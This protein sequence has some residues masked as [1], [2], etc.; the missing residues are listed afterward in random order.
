MEKQEK[1]NNCL[2]CNRPL[3]GNFCIHCGQKSS[4][5]RITF[6]HTFREFLSAS[7]SFEGPLLSTIIGLL[8]NPGKIYRDFLAGRRVPY[9]KPVA[10]FILLTAI[11]VLSR[12]LIDYDPLQ[13]QMETPATGNMKEAQRISMKAARYMVS[14]INYIMFFLVFAIG[15]SFRLIFPKRFNLSEYCTIGFYISAIYVLFGIPFMI[16]KTYLLTIP[17]QVQMIFLFLFI[18]YSAFSLFRELKPFHLIRYFLVSG[19]SIFLYVLLGFG[20]SLLVVVLGMS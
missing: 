12:L 2:N 5:G 11:Y 16:F 18:F 20:F 3:T 4:T 17:N 15:L 7:F 9:Y 14:N 10:F 1:P 13:G 6:N 19:L 8:K